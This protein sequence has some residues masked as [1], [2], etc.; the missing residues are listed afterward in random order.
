VF[1]TAQAQTTL[2]G[3]FALQGSL[4]NNVAG[5]P[6]LQLLPVAGVT[7]AVTSAGYNFAKNQGLTFLSPNMSTT[8]Y[9]IELSFRSNLDSTTSWAKLVDL[10]GK[11]TNDYGLYIYSGNGTYQLQFYPTATSSQTDFA[12][13]ANVDVMFTRDSATKLVTAYVN[14][15][16]RFSF[17]DSSDLAVITATNQMLTF[18]ADDT[19]QLG[20]EA[21]SGTVNYIRI[22]NGALTAGEVSAL[23]AN[24]APSAVPEPATTSL[25]TGLAALGGCAA[26]WRRRACSQGIRVAA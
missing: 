7:G 19:D 8:G 22:Y 23:Y 6:P 10:Y 5:G 2:L 9:S 16:L 3:E 1:L 26:W 4:A 11:G 20:N 14:G 24:G 15:G 17:T 12:V 13:G 21:A 25:L 18:F